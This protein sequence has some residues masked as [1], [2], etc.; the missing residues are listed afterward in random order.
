MSARER[1]RVQVVRDSRDAL[2][3]RDAGIPQIP[4]FDPWHSLAVL[5]EFAEDAADAPAPGVHLNIQER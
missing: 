2:I 1:E 3:R 5:V 4:G